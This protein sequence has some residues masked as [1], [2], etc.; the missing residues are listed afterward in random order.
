MSEVY[1]TNDYITPSEARALLETVTWLCRDCALTRIEAAQIES[2]CLD[3]K[4]RLV[5]EDS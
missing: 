3:C 5:M 1:N 2:I 4:I